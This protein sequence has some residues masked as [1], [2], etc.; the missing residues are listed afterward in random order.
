MNTISVNNVI[1]AGFPGGGRKIVM[2]YI[3]IN[4]RSKGLAVITV[5]MIFHQAIQL[6]GWHWNKLLC[7]HVY[8]GNNMSIYRM[9]ELSIQKLEHF[10]NIIEFIRSIH[11]IANDK[12]GQ[13]PDKFD[14]VIDN[15]FKVVFG[16][17]VQKGNIYSC[18]IRPNTTPTY[19]R[20]PIAGVPLCYSML[21]YYSY[22]KFCPSTG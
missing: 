10:P 5:A 7:I 21:Q 4:S 12:I 15:I 17:N 22:Q 19:Y 2:M 9:T 16:M 11:I 18:N 13:T 6:G 8:L 3:V 20:T 14:N 1:I